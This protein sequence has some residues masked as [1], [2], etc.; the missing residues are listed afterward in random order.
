M[1]CAYWRRNVT[2]LIDS[3]LSRAQEKRVRAHLKTCDS[4]REFYAEQTEITKAL[5]ALP[6]PSG[7]PPEVWTAISRR[8]ASEQVK[9]SPAIDSWKWWEAA[10]LAYAAAAVILLFGSLLV[11][12]QREQLKVQQLAEIDAFTYSVQGNPFYGEP[13]TP[14]NPFFRPI[15]PLGQNP[16]TR[17]RGVSK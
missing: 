16:F 3:S 9:Q 11:V 4:C 12:Q 5:R 1:I 7:P 15:D 6:T 10:R 2:A 17:S 14:E 13:A 8:I